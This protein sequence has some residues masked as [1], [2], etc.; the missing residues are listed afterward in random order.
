MTDATLCIDNA[1]ADATE[2][3]VGC[4]S[5][6]CANATGDGARR[7][8]PNSGVTR[9]RG[10]MV[11]WLNKPIDTSSSETDPS[12]RSTSYSP[13]R[14]LALRVAVVAGL[15]GMSR[16]S[17]T[18]WTGPSLWAALP[19]DLERRTSMHVA[20]SAALPTSERGES[21]R[22]MDAQQVL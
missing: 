5:Y 10:P 19:Y 6:L 11:L 22:I 15:A 9:A 7:I 14:G 16:S 18:D 3:W 1:V 20:A 4:G 8:D 12:G 2:T 21:R 17:R 13:F